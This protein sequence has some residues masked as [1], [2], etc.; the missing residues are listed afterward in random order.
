M[1][2]AGPRRFF[3]ALLAL[4]CLVGTALAFDEALVRRAERA[5]E[6]YRPQLLNISKELQ[7]PA[8]DEQQLVTFRDRL[9]LIRADA[10]KLSTSLAAPIAEVNQQLASLGPAPGGNETEPS[11][12][13]R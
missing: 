10:V 3:A 12:C 4:L 9:E 13:C 11:S 2:M 8:L 6:E 1:S 5:I 7:N